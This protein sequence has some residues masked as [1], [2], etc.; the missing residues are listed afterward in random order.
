ML[1]GLLV[2]HFLCDGRALELVESDVNPDD[3]DKLVLLVDE[4]SSSLSSLS[5]FYMD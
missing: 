2:E 1:P 3:I 4:A 5:I